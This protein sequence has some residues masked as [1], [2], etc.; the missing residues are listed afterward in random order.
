MS[1]VLSY[2]TAYIPLLLL[3][4][5]PSNA[6]SKL[7]VTTILVED[8]SSNSNGGNVGEEGS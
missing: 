4:D 8:I 1:V 3:S 7:M 2:S 5:P 6:N